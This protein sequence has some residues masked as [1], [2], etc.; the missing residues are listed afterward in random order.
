MKSLED[1]DPFIA[2]G[3]ANAD[4]VPVLAKLQESKQIL[5]LKWPLC[6]SCTVKIENELKGRD[7]DLVD[8]IGVFERAINEFTKNP[9]IVL[10]DDSVADAQ[11]KFEQEESALLAELAE[12]QE[13]ITSTNAT[14]DA[15]AQHEKDIATH[16][17]EYVSCC[18]VLSHDIDLTNRL[19][20]SMYRWHS[21]RMIEV[22]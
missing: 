8:E 19:T 20:S 1:D 4:V 7:S 14:L 11:R 15:I 2:D 16:E 6:K 10:D 21:F 17:E 12:V 5:A 3:S 13:Q 18:I 22:H 9:L